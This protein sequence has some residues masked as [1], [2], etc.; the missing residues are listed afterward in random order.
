MSVLR[1]ISI[2]LCST[3]GDDLQSTSTKESFTWRR[4]RP[5]REIMLHPLWVN[6]LRSCFYLRGRGVRCRDRLLTPAST[7]SQIRGRIPRGLLMQTRA[8]VFLFFFGGGG[9]VLRC[10]VTLSFHQFQ[11]KRSRFFPTSPCDIEYLSCI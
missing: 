7:V 2:S 8:L 11:G 6:L 9:S 3:C 1:L 5:R 4:E 10:S